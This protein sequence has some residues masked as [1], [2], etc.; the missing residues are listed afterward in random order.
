M[1]LL[2]VVQ[3][4]C[5]AVGVQRPTSVFSQIGSNRTMQEMLGVANEMATRIA[6]DTRDW[7]ALRK[8]AVI[9]GDGVATA[10][11][12]PVDYLRMLK[13][14]QV[15]RS[16]SVIQPMDF[17]PDTDQWFNRRAALLYSAWGE[18]TLYGGLLQIFPPMGPGITAYFSYLDRNVISLAAGGV[19]ERFM[20]DDDR[21]RLD[22]RL[23]TLGMIWLWKSNKGSPYAEDMGTWSDAL[24]NASSPDS[25]S[26]IIVGGSP[27]Q[28]M[29]PSPA[30]PSSYSVALEGPQGPPGP[31][32]PQGRSRARRATAAIPAPPAPRA[33]P[34]TPGRPAPLARPAPRVTPAR[35]ATPAR[36]ER[37]GRRASRVCR[38]RP[39]PLARKATPD[40]G[41]D[42][43]H[44]AA[45][46]GW[47]QRH[48]DQRHGAA[49]CGRR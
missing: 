22:E 35:K 43:R 7:T 39:A 46:A 17:Y 11:P 18:W 31:Q 27:L 1:S 44:R 28:S 4:V 9:T 19:G 32:G 10:F 16:T 37:R 47:H 21:F 49:G 24:G 20:S 13:T 12:L 29:L 38:A 5:V 41:T 42:R 45:G 25:P 48:R 34:A 26:P 36:P 15:W 8:Q 33:S 23:L 3:D 40:R 30:V 14:S 2:S 6:R